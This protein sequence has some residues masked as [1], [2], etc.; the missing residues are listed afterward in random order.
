MIA[1]TAAALAALI[2]Q[3]SQQER[4]ALSGFPAP[5][6]MLTIMV[7]DE[8]RLPGRMKHT[9]LMLFAIPCAVRTMA[10]YLCVS[11]LMRKNPRL[12][13]SELSIAGPPILPS[14]LRI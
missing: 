7:T 12:R 3:P 2:A 10:P 8:L 5:M 4:L 11:L 14:S 6:F 9:E 1:M 13:K